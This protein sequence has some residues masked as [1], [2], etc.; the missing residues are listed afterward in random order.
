MASEID[1]LK[2]ER[3]RFLAF[4]REAKARGEAGKLS[5]AEV[6]KRR[7]EIDRVL[8]ERDAA[9]TQLRTV[10]RQRDRLDAEAA[11]VD[12]EERALAAEEAQCVGTSF[13]ALTAQVLDRP[14]ALRPR[15][16]SSARPRGKSS[17]PTRAWHARAR[18]PAQNRRLQHVVLLA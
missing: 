11:A 10:E 18:A 16:A 8:Q 14:L 12:A 7:R 13:A 3:E 6:A 4:E 9:E 5:D 15:A 17:D 1:E 2:R